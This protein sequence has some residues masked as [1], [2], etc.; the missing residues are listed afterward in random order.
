MTASS[1]PEHPEKRKAIIV[2][3]RIVFLIENTF[4]P[5]PLLLKWFLQIYCLALFRFVCIVIKWNRPQYIPS[6][7]PDGMYFLLLSFHI[8]SIQPLSQGLMRIRRLPLFIKAVVKKR[9]QPK[10]CFGGARF[11][12]VGTKLRFY[13]LVGTKSC[14]RNA[15]WSLKKTWGFRSPYPRKIDP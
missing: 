14:N 3:Q 13:P 7:T 11:V 5:A 10:T 6:G 8:R 9:I 1:F 15:G 12:P 2:K 4:R